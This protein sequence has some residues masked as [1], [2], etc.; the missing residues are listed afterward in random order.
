[1]QQPVAKGLG[2]A[3]GQFAI[4]RQ[5]LGPGDEVLG[6]ERELQPDG[7]EI[8]IAE[9]EVLQA[10]LLGGADAVLG[11]GAGAVQALKLNRVAFEVG[12]VGQEAVAVV[13]G[14]G[15]LRAGARGARSRGCPRASR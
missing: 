2:L 1:M 7:V 4:E 12:Q 9:G 3:D 11:A 14:E 10:G 13:V 15:Q 5:E 8:E 6:D